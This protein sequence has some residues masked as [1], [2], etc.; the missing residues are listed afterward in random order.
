MRTDMANNL[1]MTET[2]MMISRCDGDKGEDEIGY[3]ED[4]K[5]WVGV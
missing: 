4:E 1:E 3:A 2:W 5:E